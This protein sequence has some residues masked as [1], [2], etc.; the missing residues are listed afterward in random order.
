MLESWPPRTSQ[1]DI[2]WEDEVTLELVA[3]TLYDWA[4][5]KAEVW[6]QT[7]HGEGAP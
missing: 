4:L 2:V 1:C 7:P 6:T 3:L 5:M